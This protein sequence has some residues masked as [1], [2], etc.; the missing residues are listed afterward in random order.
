MYIMVFCSAQYSSYI[1]V[2]NV[3]TFYSVLSILLS[4]VLLNKMFNKS[5]DAVIKTRMKIIF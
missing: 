1:N 4:N 3:A 5:L 2:A